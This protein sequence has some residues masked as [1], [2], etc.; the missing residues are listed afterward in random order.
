MEI[1]E[2]TIVFEILE[3]YGDIADVMETLGVRWVGKYSVRRVITR[4]PRGWYPE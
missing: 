1:T 3:K 4:F 2:R